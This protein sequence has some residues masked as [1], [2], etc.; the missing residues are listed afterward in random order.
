MS[1]INIYTTF[2]EY[3]FFDMQVIASIRFPGQVTQQV[4]SEMAARLK[5]HLD[6]GKGFSFPNLTMTN[7]FRLLEGTL[8]LHLESLTG[9]MALLA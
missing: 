1:Q 4:A 8:Q 6:S 2:S 3:G 7:S 5:Q 9:C